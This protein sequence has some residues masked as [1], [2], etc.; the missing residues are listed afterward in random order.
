MQK[1]DWETTA[2]AFYKRDKKVGKVSCNK[3]TK[4]GQ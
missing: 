2:T 4:N 3:K 1:N